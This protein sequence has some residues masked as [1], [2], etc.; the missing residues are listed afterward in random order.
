MEFDKWILLVRELVW[1]AVAL[2]LAPFLIWRLGE[3]VRLYE[4]IKDGELLRDVLNLTE[5]VKTRLE[6]LKK[7]SQELKEDQEQQVIQK[8]YESVDKRSDIEV[9]QLE[10]KFLPKP[11]TPPEELYKRMQSA[12]DEL[13]AIVE[14]KLAAIG[15]KFDG[16]SLRIAVA[17][18]Q[19]AQSD[20]EFINNLQSQYSRFRSLKGT[21]E[22]WLT[23][24]IYSDFVAR[25]VKAKKLI[26]KTA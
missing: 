6:E 13:K 8:V 24:E 22:E 15:R 26:D 11:N 17:P 14:A 16:R 20:A 10:E 4:A 25:V 23:P 3:I 19:L 1:P 18:L 12:W 2:A 9:I 21:T 5:P 7:L